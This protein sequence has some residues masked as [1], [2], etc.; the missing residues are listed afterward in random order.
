MSQKT[1]SVVN[2]NGSLSFSSQATFN[3]ASTN[4]NLTTTGEFNLTSNNNITFETY[5]GNLDIIADNNAISISSNSSSNTAIIIQATN[6]TGGIE[7]TTGSGGYLLTT[8]DGDIDLL[9]QGANVNVGVSVVGTPANQQT[10][11]INL[12]CFNN[13]NAS[14]GDMYFVSSDV[15]SFVSN[16]GDIQ[17]GTSSNGVPVIKFQDGN[18]LINQAS[19]NQDYQLDI[20]VSDASTTHPGYNGIMI[21]S[22]QSNVASDITLQTSNTLGDGTQGIISMG[23]FGSDNSY[24]NFQ[25]YLGYQTANV[26]IRLDG[27]T[28]SPGQS[29]IGFGNDFTINDIGRQIYWPTLD[30][31]DTI[32]GLGTYITPTNDSSN[33]TVSGSYDGNNSRVYLLQ[34]DSI[35]TPNT[36]MWSNNGG[37]SF[38]QQF[39][40]ITSTPITLDPGLQVTFTQTTGFVLN[41]Q[42]IFQAKITAMVNT[43]EATPTSPTTFY[44]LQPYYAYIKTTT[45][46]DIVIKTNNTEK[47]RITGDGA[48]GIQKKVPNACL[49][50]DSNY[51][52]VLLVNQ[53]VS[54]YQINPSVSYLTSGGYV[55]VWN[56]QDN[57][58]SLDFNV[59]GQRYLSDGS[60]YST[61]FQINNLTSGNQSFP[62][63]AGSRLGNSNHYIVTWAGFNSTYNKYK[64][65]YQIF[66]NNE[67]IYGSDYQLDVINTNTSDQRYP[68]AAGL[69]NGNYVI[70]WAAD[71]TGSGI[72]VINSAII[73][74]NGIIIGKYQVS[75]TPSPTPKSSN[76]PYVAGLPSDDANIP[77][78]YVVGFMTAV[79]TNVDP[80]YTIAVRVMNADGTPGTGQIPITSVGSVAYS[81]ISDGLLSV[82]E[83]NMHQVN[84][85][86]GNGGFV[87]SFYRNYQADTTLYQVGDNLTGLL[88]GA[89]ATIASL[90]PVNRII[91]VQDI[92]NRLLVGEEIDISSS[93]SGVGNI[94][95]KINNI[96]FTTDTTATITLDT[97]SKNVVAYRFPSNLTSTS[98]AIWNIQVNTSPLY[99]DTDRF[100][101]NVNVFTY[102]R[103]LA[104]ICVDNEGT[105]LVTWSNGSIPSVYYQLIDIEKNGELLG[106]EQRLTSGYD[107]LKQRDQVATIL[108]SIEGNDY[109]FLIS[110]DNQSLDLV[111]AGV[112]QQLIG[113]DH[114]LLTL[115]DGNSSF[116][117]NHQSYCGIGTNAPSDSLHIKS[118]ATSDFNDPA[119]PAGIIIQNTSQHVITTTSLQTIKFQ[120]GNS[121]NL[122]IIRSKN[123]IRYDD[124]APQPESLIGFYK[125][126]DNQGTQAKDS[127]SYSSYLSGGQPIFINTSAILI[128]FDFENCWYP[129]LIN[130][131]LLFDGNN[132]YCYVEAAAPNGL[133]T[134]LETAQALSISCWV[135]VPTNV[136]T[137]ATYNLISNGGNMLIAGT[138]IL[139][140][141]DVGSNGHMLPSISVSLNSVGYNTT[142]TI[143]INDDTW[144]H[145]VAVVSLDGT[146][147]YISLYVDGVLDGSF[148][149]SGTITSVQHA[150]IDTFIGT[151]NDIQTSNYYRGYL[152]EL[153]FYDVAL[154]Y[155]DISTLY[156]YGN[157]NASPRGA[158]ILN[159]NDNSSYNLGLVLDDTGKLN[160]LSSKPLPYSILS[161]ELIANSTNATITGNG[162]LFT[163]EIT[164]GD[165]ISFNIS[166]GTTLDFTVIEIYNDTSLLL[167]QQVYTGPE[168]TKA[169]QS[170]LRRP[171]IYTFFD[172]GDNIKGHIDGYGNL[173][174]GGTRPSTMLEVAGATGSSINIPEIT[175]TN[176]SQDDDEYGRKTAVNF[177]GYNAGAGTNPYVVLGHIE[178]S[179]QGNGNDNRGIMKFYTNDGTQE[180]NILS[181]TSN[182]YV[183][184]GN[185][186]L[187]LGMV[188]VVNQNTLKECDLILE[189]SYIASTVQAGSIYDERS[190]LY[191]AGYTSIND[192]SSTDIKQKVLSAISG[193][194]DG[195]GQNRYGRLDFLTNNENNVNGIE[196]RMSITHTGNIGMCIQSPPNI[197]SMAPELRINNGLINT[198]TTA[199]FSTSTTV[200]TLNQNIF[201]SL[202]DDQ[203]NMFINGT[204]I[205]DNNTLTRGTIISVATIV[206]NQL[207]VAGDFS[208][209]AG[210]K[211]YIHYPGLNITT[212]GFV[213]VNTTA[214][215]AP[216]S[217]IGS[218]SMSI[219]TVNSDTTLDITHHTM[220]VN[221]ASGNITIT[222]PINS[223]GITGRIYKIKNIGSNNVNILPN[224]DGGSIDSSP[225]LTLPSGLGLSST[226]AIL[227]SDGTNWW[228]FR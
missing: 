11:N 165:M 220:L 117:F 135:N 36:F 162:T 31:T 103:P 74:D 205:I 49:D 169:Y 109:G 125:F 10:Q 8:I 59:I 58:S 177:R 20:A 80:R 34:I 180:N 127:S 158:L 22:F 15:I 210:K 72:Y 161:G 149:Y 40:P 91:Y 144:H 139:K 81:N 211:C 156:T 198:I 105:G 213:G 50:L 55:L 154:T 134:V 115:T 112:Y 113:Y 30:K 182:G 190:N 96:T 148:T 73:Q 54:G 167:D 129:G 120:D 61:N 78:G 9:S 86:Y 155:D 102:K 79:D 212:T 116:T 226:T 209:Y 132:D 1:L 19:S 32:K 151:I 130:S 57:L 174:I 27:P 98:S 51:N 33:V 43:I 168:A 218:I 136:V 208:S 166:M 170:V 152:D 185:Q 42:F 24:A 2:N 126:D 204:I 84:T 100:S 3:C 44:T 17:F 88:S 38:V 92:S 94:I 128:N 118:N 181:L 199:V 97:G 90:D 52:K 95:E 124:L 75:I 178:T 191:F 227:Q 101:G 186:N 163:T 171:S 159:A 110:W 123:A 183:G 64:I 172:N 223:P 173:M 66:H 99:A 150:A 206:N 35:A 138:Y 63:V 21:N 26:V 145:L 222:L 76:F 47:M 39:V 143:S 196:P 215:S 13:L 4:Y 140:L 133:N 62:S 202:S 201:T 122:N 147:C 111:D 121:N 228:F 41:Q 60:R 192:S 65:Y 12:E 164:V 28:Y 203:R 108:Q 216:L 175:I 37:L 119:N 137:G 67:P 188:H 142:G 176:T 157:P 83:I 70:V 107:G 131:A 7:T 89:T 184:I 224:T 69:Y 87:M 5:N 153:R 214:P 189:S 93:I 197:I 25:S 68:R 219:I 225:N 160:N 56:S 217:V 14:A 187:P 29:Y 114:A 18:V 179:H 194:N 23:V 48:I 221:T 104:A 82:A 200:I 16:T 71:D 53:T 77:N 106:I 195:L 45:P 46:S 207:T 6:T 85:P 146:N 141:Q 193:S